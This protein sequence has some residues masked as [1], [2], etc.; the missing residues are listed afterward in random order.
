MPQNMRSP[1]GCLIL[2]AAAA[3]LPQSA[4]AQSF[5]GRNLVRN[6]GA[7][8]G[9]AP[10][11]NPPLVRPI[12]GWNFSIGNFTIELYGTPGGFP[13]ASSPGPPNRGARFFSGG[14]NTITS[15]GVQDI[16]VPPEAFGPIDAGIAKYELLGWVGGFTSQPDHADIQAI[17]FQGGNANSTT[18]GI[19]APDRKGV[20]GL[21]QVSQSGTVPKNTRKFQIVLNMIGGSGNYDDAYADEISFVLTSPPFV[22]SAGVA[23]AASYEAKGVA[24]GEIIGIF[25][26]T[27]GPS[28]GVVG[29]ITSGKFNTSVSGVRVLFD[30]VPAPI[31]YASSG[32]LSAIVPYGLFQKATTQLV[33]EYNG[34]R[35]APVTLNVIVSVPG[36]FAADGSGIGQGAIF[37]ENGSLNNAGTPAA[38]GSIIVFYATGEGQTFPSGADGALAL[39]PDYPKPILPVGVTI[40]GREAEILYYGAAPTLVA[41]AMQ[42]NARIPNG[43]PAGNAPIILR[44]GQNLSP[45]TVTVAVK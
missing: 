38:A 23:N 24:P 27:L 35:S 5:Y 14:P 18:P 9:P 33:V 28:T 21:F 11:G 1:I 22:T 10:A 37:N 34:T 2:L 20:T 16:D 32:Q 19:P 17:F 31:I 39:G 29:A 43:T 7:E 25:G 26:V 8:E 4:F 12:P 40:G 42:V 41:G 13:T 6:G 36:I 30:D 15:F 44:V 3:N 45:S